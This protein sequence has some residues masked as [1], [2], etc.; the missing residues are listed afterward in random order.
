MISFKVGRRAS[1]QTW[2]SGDQARF[3]PG[4]LFMR[5]QKHNSG[6]FCAFVG[7][8]VFLIQ[9]GLITTSVMASLLLAMRYIS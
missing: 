7:V 5:A 9:V 6:F 2:A 1:L 3:W 8:A 4:W